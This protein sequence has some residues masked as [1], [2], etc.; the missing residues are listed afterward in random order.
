MVVEG[1]EDGLVEDRDVM[2]AIDLNLDRVEDEPIGF[3]KTKTHGLDWELALGHEPST[4][5]FF[6]SKKMMD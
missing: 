3:D 4:I 5:Q 6:L 1:Q 2:L